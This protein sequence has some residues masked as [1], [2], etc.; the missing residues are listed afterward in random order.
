ME[1]RTHA[2]P[3]PT[4]LSILVRVMQAASTLEL[5]LIT[6]SSPLIPQV[7]LGELQPGLHRLC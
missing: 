2:A 5:W 4:L 1:A 3:L 6:T 7:G